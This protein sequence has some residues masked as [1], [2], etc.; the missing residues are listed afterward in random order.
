[1][2]RL[3]LVAGHEDSRVAGCGGDV[4]DSIGVRR[5]G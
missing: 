5:W 3:D 4:F 2:V 1:M